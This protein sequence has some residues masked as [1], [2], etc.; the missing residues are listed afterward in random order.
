MVNG[1]DRVTILLMEGSMQREKQH[2]QIVS[3]GAAGGRFIEGY[4]WHPSQNLQKM[5]DIP[6]N[7][8]DRRPW[9]ELLANELSSA[10]ENEELVVIAC[11]VLK[12][13]HRERL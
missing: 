11:S 6:L 2:W 10:V 12:K 13:D 3:Q 9:L 1:S 5:A 8:E 7:E 4:A